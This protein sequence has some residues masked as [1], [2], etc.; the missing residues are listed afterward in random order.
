M[1]GGIDILTIAYN[2]AAYTAKSLPALL[3]SCTDNTRIWLW[4]NGSDPETSEVIQQYRDDPRIYKFHHSVEN[5]RLR[6]PTNWLWQEAKGEYLGKI[7]DDGLVP[8]DWC[9]R[10]PA[11]HQRCPELGVLACCGSW[12]HWRFSVEPQRRHMSSSIF[13]TSR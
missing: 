4:Q 11:A 2:R 6:V 8:R 3:E 9:H 12:S 7:D 1:T 5:Q 13:V 10:L